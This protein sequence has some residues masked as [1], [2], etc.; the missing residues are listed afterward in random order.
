M[1]EVKSYK[2]IT[3]LI[4]DTTKWL[5]HNYQNYPFRY[6]VIENANSLI[7]F[8][9]GTTIEESIEYISSSIIEY[10][11]TSKS[12]FTV[13]R[14]NKDDN[15]EYNQIVFIVTET[16]KYNSVKEEVHS[17]DDFAWKYNDQLIVMFDG[18]YLLNNKPEYFDDSCFLSEKEPS[19]LQ[20]LDSEIFKLYN[21]CQK[22]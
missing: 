20:T 8:G 22:D 6:S 7:D 18:R 5:D 14:K 1:Y 19:K 13:L 10:I 11:G 21:T 17:I 3:E 4:L 2:N 15:I 12:G 9:N 16:S